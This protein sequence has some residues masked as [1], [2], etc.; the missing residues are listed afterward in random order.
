VSADEV[1]GDANEGEAAPVEGDASK[2]E[3]PQ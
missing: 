2:A 3:D 1:P